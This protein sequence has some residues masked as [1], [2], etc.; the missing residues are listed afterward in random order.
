[1]SDVLVAPASSANLGRSSVWADWAGMTASIGCA[2]H[3]AAMPLV[4]AYLPAFGLGWLADEG[5]H[6]W[7]A[8]ICF[9][10]AIAAFVPGWRRH[11]SLAPAKWGAVGL[12]LL[13]TASFGM[14][15]TCCPP[16]STDSANVVAVEDSCGD[17]ACSSCEPAPKVSS[18]TNRSSLASLAILATPLGGVLLVIGHL[19]NHRK[20]CSCQENHCCITSDK[21]DSDE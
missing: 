15:D 9:A 1:M 18:E 4:L 3:C 11:G 20:S 17:A 5:F 2:I 10:L 7:M 12:L 13:M 19:V 14:E 16:H 8:V 6:R 21:T